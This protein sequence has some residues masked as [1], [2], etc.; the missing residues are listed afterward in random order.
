[1]PRRPMQIDASSSEEEDVVPDFWVKGV[2]AEA[3]GDGGR[4][5]LLVQWGQE[6]ALRW[7]SWLA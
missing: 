2:V 1:M 5:F 7:F 6:R 4:R 3:A